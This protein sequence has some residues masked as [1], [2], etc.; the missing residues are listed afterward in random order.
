MNRL[1]FIHSFAYFQNEQTDSEAKI[2]MIGSINLILCLNLLCAITA[3]PIDFNNINNN[4]GTNTN[5]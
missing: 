3:A 2:K 1:H 4:Q 5:I